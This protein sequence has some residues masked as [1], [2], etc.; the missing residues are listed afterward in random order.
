LQ[1]RIS[2]EQLE[3]GV[4]G[5]YRKFSVCILPTII[6]GKPVSTVGLGD[7]VSSATFLR[8]LEVGMD[9]GEVTT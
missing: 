8:W 5:E 1:D 6:C 7:T 3:G 4:C 2:G 9:E